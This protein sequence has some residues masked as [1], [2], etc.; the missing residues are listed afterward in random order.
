MALPGVAGVFGGY[1][2][3]SGYLLDG[4]SAFAAY[5]PFRDLNET[6]AGNSVVRVI[7][8][9][10]SAQS[11]FTATDVNDGTLE[12]WVGVGNTGRVVTLYDQSGNARHLS[13]TGDD[14]YLVY[15]GVLL[16]GITFGN[17]YGTGAAAGDQLFKNG[18]PNPSSGA[19]SVLLVAERLSAGPGNY[20]AV[21]SW[22]GASQGHPFALETGRIAW[23][24]GRTSGAFYDYASFGFM[25]TPYASAEVAASNLR[26][27]VYNGTALV[28][29]TA[30]FTPA[31]V[32]GQ[33]GLGLYPW[34][35]FYHGRIMEAV[36]VDG[37]LQTQASALNANQMVYYG[38]S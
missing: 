10:D 31:F 23:G 4:L 14:P 24:L 15:N 37:N 12:S 26:Y 28:N 22:S 34:S 38:I 35:R 29:E 6:T 19:A 21:Y 16:S 9:S 27:G 7:R 32:G 3:G 17:T 36:F 2:S 1:Q 8:S 11:N 25:Y 20:D 5:S 18:L 30:S 13:A 33:I